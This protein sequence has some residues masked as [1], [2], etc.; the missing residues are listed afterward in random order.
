MTLSNNIQSAKTLLILRTDAIGDNVIGSALLEPLRKTLPNSRIIYACQDR[1]AELFAA[2]PFVDQIIPFNRGRACADE[3]YRAE[4]SR[5]LAALNA[6]ILLNPTLTREPL[7]DNFAAECR[8]PLHIAFQLPSEQTASNTVYTHLIKPNP[9]WRLELDRVAEFLHDL[10]IEIPAPQPQLWLTPA[11]ESFAREL[12]AKHHFDPTRTITLFAGAL[13]DYRVNRQ[14]GRALALAFP[15]ADQQ[16]LCLGAAHEFALHEELLADYAGKHLNLCGRTTLLQTAALIK[17]ARLALGAETGAIQLACAVGTP[18]VAVVGGG[19]FGRFVPWSPLTTTVCLPLACFRCDWHCK[20]TRHHCIADI[21]AETIAAGIREAAS[22]PSAKPRIVVQSWDRQ[23]PDGPLVADMTT[24]ISQTLVEIISASNS[25][26]APSD[27]KIAATSLPIPARLP[28][29][30]PESAAD[31]FRVTAIV[32]T[33]NSEK[34]LRGCLQDL[35]DQTLFEA[36]QLEILI[37]DAASPQNEAAIA[38]EFQEAHGTGRIRYHRTPHR[39]SLYASWNRAI[40]L[41]RG[42]YLTNANTDD[43]HHPDMLARLAATLDASPD[44]VLAYCNSHITH[45]ANASWQDARRIR[46]PALPGFSRE[47]LFT[48]SFI[49]PHPMWRKS[50][51]HEAG[52]FDPAFISAGDYEFWLRLSLTHPFIHL[53]EALGLCLENP[54]GISLGNQGLTWYELQLARQRYWKKEWGADPSQ[55]SILT[56]FNDLA[57]RASALPGGARIALFGAGQ[58]TGRHLARFR[59]ALEPHAD[60]VAILDDRP[61]AVRDL[62]GIPIVHSDRWR[63]LALDAIVLSS[64]T[65]EAALAARAIKVTG[66]ILPVI[67]VYKPVLDHHPA[68]GAS[69]AHRGHSQPVMQTPAAPR[70]ESAA[71]SSQATKELSQSPPLFHLQVFR[72]NI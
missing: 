55:R 53:P 26:D 56:A 23:S 43:R 41:A 48:D 36:G 19:H 5:S 62:A 8:A 65:Y 60:L 10:G 11:D 32:S 12:F 21:S 31:Q 45:D 68:A 1:A 6:D 67:A 49:G 25:T 44:A 42:A 14:F 34:F 18:N 72:K 39:E 35:V 70:L 51:H 20:Y 27:P 71:L 7:A 54:Q 30:A 37:I 40:G 9:N 50:V 15:R 16:I 59:E 46:T 66:G 29:P 33:Y 69:P 22:R 64:D 28:N 17:R 47:Q 4:I 3:G 58:H 61:S 57:R 38:R 52:Y 63:T 13:A 24:F 2:C